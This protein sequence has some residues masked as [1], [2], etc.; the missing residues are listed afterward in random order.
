MLN[1][2]GL[3]D[4]WVY[5]LLP[6]GESVTTDKQSLKQ[7]KRRNHF[8]GNRKAKTEFQTNFKQATYKHL[9]PFTTEL[10]FRLW[11]LKDML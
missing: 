9:N 8:I 5:M 2:W 6:S 11:Q 7:E 4:V 3:R 10:F 1:I